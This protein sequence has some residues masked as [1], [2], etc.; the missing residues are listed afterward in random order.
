V[1]YFEVHSMNTSKALELLV[2]TASVSWRRVA[3]PSA[4]ES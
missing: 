4:V 1:H 3:K 2:L